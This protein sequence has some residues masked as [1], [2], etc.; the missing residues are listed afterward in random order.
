M[1]RQDLQELDLM[2]TAEEIL[3]AVKGMPPNRAPWP[4]G[5]IACL[6]QKAWTITKFG[7]MVVFHKHCINYYKFLVYFALS[8]GRCKTELQ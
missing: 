6:L 2:F 3:L 8:Y 4:D 1:E 5:F 7:V